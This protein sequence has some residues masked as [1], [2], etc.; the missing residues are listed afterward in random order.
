MCVSERE[1]ERVCVCE[2]ESETCTDVLLET[3]PREVGVADAGLPPKDA[4]LPPPESKCTD[5][6]RKTMPAIGR[7]LLGYT[8][9]G[10]QTPVAQGRSTK[11]I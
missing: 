2:G 7:K 3:I 6:R 1:R 10:I 5:G 8:E 9:K 4:G 11:T